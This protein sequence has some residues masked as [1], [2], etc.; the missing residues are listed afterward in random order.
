MKLNSLDLSKIRSIS[1][2]IF[3]TTLLRDVWPEEL[4]FIEVAKQWIQCFRESGF[5]DITA[6]ELLTYRNYARQILLNAFENESDVDKEITVNDWF[7]EIIRLIALKYDVNLTEKMQKR[8]VKQMIKIEL[9]VESRHLKANLSLVEFLETA[10]KKYNLRIV[11]ISDMYLGKEDVDQLLKN[12]GLEQL[13]DDGITSSGVGM[14]KYSGKLYR[15]VHENR[16]VNLTTNLHIGDNIVSDYHAAISEGSRAIHYKT[17]HHATRRVKELLGRRK[18]ESFHNKQQYLIRK[19]LISRIKTNTH[20]D[21][22]VGTVFAA[23]L[24]NYVSAFSDRAYHQKNVHFVGVSS[25]ATV[26]RQ[27]RDILYAGDNSQ[28]INM[29]PKLN[30]KAALRATIFEISKNPDKYPLA[31]AN[32][33]S[34]GEG[35]ATLADIVEFLGAPPPS[36]LLNGMNDKERARYLKDLIG[37]A[38]LSSK[39]NIAKDL[40]FDEYKKIVLLDVGWG[41][42]DSGFYSR[43]CCFAG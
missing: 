18:V 21:A 10:R 42:D 32:L 20:V 13:F 41:G 15:Y 6:Y 40:F 9:N 38:D 26:F 4:Q 39:L 11:Y 14:G 19:N 27:T 28:N 17:K 36:L 30:R 22:K 31:T 16:I 12:A 37:D 1:V 23:P 43:T 8:L 35:T 24:I 34:Y 7:C 3:D 29:I 33:V 2:D 5:D 25:E